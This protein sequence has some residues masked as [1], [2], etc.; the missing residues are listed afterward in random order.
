MFTF[1]TAIMVAAVSAS[2]VFTVPVRPYQFAGYVS[3]SI[4]FS[5][6]APITIGTYAFFNARGCTN[7]TFPASVSR[8]DAFAFRN[9]DVANVVMYAT[10]AVDSNAFNV[11]ATQTVISQDGRRV[12][13]TM[14]GEQFLADEESS[15]W[16]DPNTWN[17]VV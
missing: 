10:T 5:N 17:R 3:D 6:N 15:E 12:C 14:S 8:I 1:I 9:S 11:L 16:C 13:T 7:V 4:A 2:A